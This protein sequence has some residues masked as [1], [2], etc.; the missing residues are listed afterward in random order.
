M[1]SVPVSLPDDDKP[2][3]AA[4]EPTP[5][6]K[7]VRRSSAGALAVGVGIMATKVFGIV[8]NSFLAKYLGAGVVADAFN[9][10]IR[11]PGL[12][13]NLFGDG[14]MSAAFIPVYARLLAEGDEE[15]AGRVAGAVFAILALLVVVL[16]ALGV[17]FTPQLLPILAGGFKGEKRDLAITFVRILFPASGAFV[18]AAWALGVLNSHRKFLLSYSAGIAWNVAIIV[19]LL[20]YG[21]KEPLPELARITC[22]ASVVGAALQ[23]LVQL[24]H[25]IRLVP[26]LKIALDYKRE[27]VSQVMRN[28]APVFVSRGVVQISNFIDIAIASFMPNGLVSLLTYATTISYVPVSMFGM[29]ISAAELPELASVMGAHEERN[30]QLR[31]RVNAGLRQV[32]FFVV[33]S[34]VAMLAVGDLMAAALFQRGKFTH[35]DSLYTWSI[36]AGSAFGLL[37]GTMGRLYSSTYYALHDTRTPLNFAVVRVILT[38]VLGYLFAIKL[39][40]WIGIDPHWGG[41]GLTISFG[42]AGW[43]EFTLLRRGMNARIGVTGA[44]APL[45]VKLWGSALVAGAAAFGLKAA[46]GGVRPVILVVIDLALFAAVYGAAGLALR[47]PEAHALVRR[48]RR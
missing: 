46:L 21:G 15:E 6:G 11:I 14:A 31:E 29:A 1:A 10:A 36:L 30:R 38:S 26:K 47:V 5:A 39:P 28:F 13:Q 32:A 33:P 7:P 42:I 44:P 25:V 40:G 17:V 3:S 2:V 8:R 19:A 45:M 24:P 22:W 43:V 16:V 4:D 23:F 48:V 12:L 35:Q 34:A 9:A 37:A 20:W 18:L 41:A 27:R